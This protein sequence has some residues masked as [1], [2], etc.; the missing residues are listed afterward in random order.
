MPFAAALSTALPT[1][2]AARQV[3]ASCGALADADL[4]VVFFS[5]HHADSALDLTRAIHDRLRPRVLIGCIGEA[6]VGVGREI[7]HA[8]ALSL[9]LARWPEGVDVIPFHL[10]PETT[11]DGLS[12]LGW[13]DALVEGAPEVAAVLILGDPFTFPAIEIFLPQVNG[14]CRGVP[15]FGGMASGMDG[16]GATPLILGRDVHTVGA[17]GVVLRGPVSVAGV[18]SQ[19]CRPVGK[20]F[21]V[22]KAQDH[23]VLELG[24]RPALDQLR[25]TYEGL[26]PHDQQL[27]QRGPHVGLVINEYLPTF[28]RGDFLVRNV[29]AVDRA[30]GAM[31]ITDRARVGQTLQFHVRDADT[32]DEDLRLMLDQS[33]GSAPA[34]A[35]M[36]TC[37]GR[38]SRL[39]GAPH[40]D[41]AAVQDVLGAIP[42][43]GL[44][45]A[46]EFGPI[47]GQNFLHG[48]TASVVVFG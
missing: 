21:V 27:F 3:C 40:H 16:P 47:G 12:L 25:A 43:A 26:S 5:P 44:F 15:V 23:H 36:F 37:N 39:F 14:D 9:W 35:L 48:F 42:L 31:T 28:Q 4:G 34:A 20:P 6:I 7:E 46:G 11:P 22:T 32:A 19:G 13:P 17:V 41:A 24:G 38:G 8:P 45:A 2:E 33:R 30:S 29:Y 10:A 18:V 1:A